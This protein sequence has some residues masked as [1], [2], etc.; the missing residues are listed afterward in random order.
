[1]FALIVFFAC[2]KTRIF[3]LF[4]SAIFLME[5]E[6]FIFFVEIRRY[7]A[8]MT[9]VCNVCLAGCNLSQRYQAVPMFSI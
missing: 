9:K 7:S 3:L 8:R 6:N 5:L 2:A 1:M 4:L